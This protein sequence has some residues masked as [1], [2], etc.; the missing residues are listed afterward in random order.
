MLLGFN[1]FVLFIVLDSKHLIVLDTEFQQ[2]NCSF[3]IELQFLFGE[4]CHIIIDI[5]E[6]TLL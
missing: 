5:L 4:S 3:I 1:L 6:Q 2:L